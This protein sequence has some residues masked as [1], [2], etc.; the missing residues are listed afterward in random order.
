MADAS[1]TR[2]TDAARRSASRRRDADPEEFPLPG[3]LRGS[4]TRG[5]SVRVVN[6]S[7]ADC[8]APPSV[9]SAVID[10]SDRCVVRNS[11]L[12]RFSPFPKLGNDRER[13]GARCVL[14][15][16]DAFPSHVNPSRIRDASRIGPDR[17]RSI[18][19]PARDGQYLYR[20]LYAG[21]VQSEMAVIFLDV[22]TRITRKSR[23]VL[24]MYFNTMRFILTLNSCNAVR[25][26][27]DRTCD[28][29]TDRDNVRSAW[30]IIPRAT[31][32]R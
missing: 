22:Y 18:L 13:P 27:R 9:Q 4:E 2:G 26:D 7:P 3:S 19:V 15:A 14:R 31:V 23:R 32:Y 24:S 10:A 6:W 8:T 20:G 29:S 12:R 11:R 1:L 28:R 16:L 21:K 30:S 17:R 25:F 5:R